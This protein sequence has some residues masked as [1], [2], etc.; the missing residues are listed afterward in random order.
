MLYEE[1][2]QNLLMKKNAYIS[3]SHLFYFRNMRLI[4]SFLNLKIFINITFSKHYMR[5]E[6]TTHY[7]FTHIFKKHNISYPIF[8]SRT[9]VSFLILY[10]NVFFMI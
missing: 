3:S 1:H 4:H 7:K 2:I 6:K 9:H 5:N 8:Q 10:E